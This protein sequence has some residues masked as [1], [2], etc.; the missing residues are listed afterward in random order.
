MAV[1]TMLDTGKKYTIWHLVFLEIRKII[2]QGNMQGSKCD[3]YCIFLWELRFLFIL[4][5]ISF[6]FWPCSFFFEI[7][8]P[9]LPVMFSTDLRQLIC[10]FN[11]RAYKIAIKRDSV[12]KHFLEVTK[13]NRSR[14]WV[15]L[16]IE[17][18]L[19]K[20]KT[21]TTCFVQDICHNNLKDNVYG[22]IYS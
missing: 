10:S 4:Q 7:F 21:I 5:K 1:S 2:L 11:K 14:L 16:V 9:Q 19:L 20:L 15:S 8:L 17:S 3:E 22:Q 6:S 13:R 18:F 12:P